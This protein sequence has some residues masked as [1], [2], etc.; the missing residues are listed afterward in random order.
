MTSFTAHCEELQEIFTF[1]YCCEP[2]HKNVGKHVHVTKIYEKIL[3]F[4]PNLFAICLVTKR[5]INPY[6]PTGT[7]RSIVL[8]KD[9]GAK[10]LICRKNLHV[11]SASKR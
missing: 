1:E 9:S 10:I 4:V 8:E 11:K 2:C 5:S 3:E 7:D 6:W